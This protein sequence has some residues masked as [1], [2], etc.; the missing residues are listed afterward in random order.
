MFSK[1]KEIYTIIN[2]YRVVD[3]SAALQ[4]PTKKLRENLSKSL[5]D[6]FD[7]GFDSLDLNFG[8]KSWKTSRGL[9]SGLS[10]IDDQEIV[11]I[12]QTNKVN[13]NFIRISNAILNRNE[14]EV[15]YGIV[16]VQI[17]INQSQV[18]KT[19]AKKLMKETLNLIDFDYGYI[20][21]LNQDYDFDTERKKK[22]GFFGS[23]SGSQEIDLIW[24]TH[25]MAM[26]NGYLKRLYE[27]NY[28]NKSHITKSLFQMFKSKSIGSFEEINSEITQW[29][30]D[31]DDYKFALRHLREANMLTSDESTYRDFLKNMSNKN[32]V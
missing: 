14:G 6:K 10:K 27:I 12:R 13:D 21:Q 24:R 29:I 8:F 16:E 5:K 32:K 7:I 18:N 26:K 17:C 3:Y 11:Y 25:G 23:N 28:L 30:L 4:F 31:D 1:K 19:E 15:S 2:I 9:E 22:R 20:I